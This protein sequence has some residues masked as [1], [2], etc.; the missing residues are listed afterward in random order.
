MLLT[1]RARA[2]RPF[3]KAS[4]QALTN[5]SSNELWHED[6]AALTGGFLREQ[7]GTGLARYPDLPNA[8]AAYRAQMPAGQAV[9]L[10]PGADCGLRELAQ[11][12]CGTGFAVAPRD[13][14]PAFGH[15]VAMAGARLLEIE[16]ESTADLAAGMAACIAERGPCL[17]CIAD[18]DGITGAE[19]ARAQRGAIEGAVVAGGGLLI[20]DE[21]YGCF[22]GQDPLA[23]PPANPNVLVLRS[24]SKSHGVAGLRL[25]LLF[26]A[27]ALIDTVEAARAINANSALSLAFLDWALRHRP[28][29]QAIARDVAARRA[30]FARSVRRADPRVACPP[31]HGNF[32]YLRFAD[33]R[34]PRELASTLR[35]RDIVVRGFAEASPAHR[36]SLRVTIG[37]PDA[38]E[39]VLAA[40]REQGA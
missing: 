3:F 11:L 33:A 7:C 8:L 27:Q 37:P 18:P 19:L 12:F 9:T 20:W 28:A 6:L 10:L 15:G 13:S 35:Q 16:A 38:L 36:A 4:Y 2:S 22:G 23:P 24:F 21:A 31:G 5:L 1:P 17:V 14:Y 29:Y 32:Q 34:A 39:A 40:I 25:A 30:T 26:G